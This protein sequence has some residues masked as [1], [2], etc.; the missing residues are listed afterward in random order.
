[1]PNKSFV[2]YFFRNNR[3]IAWFVGLLSISVLSCLVLWYFAQSISGEQSEQ[4]HAA[5][6]TSLSEQNYYAPKQS[7]ASC[8]DKEYRLWYDSNH[9]RAM[10]EPIT[11]GFRG[12]FNDTQYIHVGFDDLAELSDD[13]LKA[14]LNEVDLTIIAQGLTDAKPTVLL[15][16]NAVLSP[17]NQ[18]QLAK[19]THHYIASV[20]TET[21]TAKRASDGSAMTFGKVCPVRAGDSQLAHAEVVDT[22]QRLA[23]EGKIDL[24]FGQLYRFFMQ[25]NRPMVECE[26]SRGEREIFAVKYTF[27]NSPMQ[28]YLV[29]F[30]DG[31]VQCLPM[32]WDVERGRW[33]HLYPKERILHDDVLFWTRPAQN[34]NYMCAG[35]HTTN[36]HKNYD[37][38]SN[39]YRTR[40]SEMGVGCQSCHGPGGWHVER[41][42]IPGIT[43]TG[44]RATDMALPIFSQMTAQDEVETCAPC[45]AHRRVLREG[46]APPDSHFLDYYVPAMIDGNLFYADGQILE[47]DYEYTSFMQCRMSVEN[48]RCT[49][50]HDPHTSKL[51]HNGNNLCLQCHNAGYDSPKHHFHEDETQPGTQCIECH[52]PT[53]NYMVIRPRHDHNFKVPDPDLTIRLGIPNACN[54][55]H[56]DPVKSETPEWASRWIRHWY[57]KSDQTQPQ[58]EHFAYAISGG[59][60]GNADALPKLLDVAT[61]NDVKQVRPIVRASAIALLG[62]YPTAE[63]LTAR[64]TALSDDDPNVR[65]AAASTFESAMPD[66][67]LTHLLPLLDDEKY[68]IR[69]EAARLLSVVPPGW[70]PAD[71]K[72]SYQTTLRDY[73]ESQ[74]ASLDHPAAHLNLAVLWENLAMPEIYA[75]QGAMPI[76]DVRKRTQISLDAYRQALAI[77]PDFLPARINLAMLHNS[78]NEPQE[79]EIQLRRVTE[80]APENGEGF[81]SLALLLAEQNRLD[82]AEK[83]FAKAATLMPDNARLLY[84]HGLLLLQLGNTDESER[85]LIRAYQADQNSV[86]IMRALVSVSLAKREYEKALGRIQLLRRMEPNNPSWQALFN[87]VQLQYRQEQNRSE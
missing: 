45:H 16:I 7:C 39:T 9:H 32:T 50:C 8:H 76:T 66:E 11:D 21:A 38:A 53:H 44:N 3:H 27:G 82:E 70:F 64:V 58:R 65:L 56:N 85:Q 40:W 67:R 37:V 31:R 54:N 29:E 83:A 33:F 51:T 87:Q 15:R 81:Y 34:W 78:R 18:E 14:V 17:E 46:A 86:D 79:A 42:S 36:L 41:M 61:N 77:D 26:N 75:A 25:R 13:E 57:D 5:R 30:D 63:T 80:I 47:E 52:A 49:T 28:Q 23:I 24:S 10:G 35:C 20:T 68:A 73:V 2:A 59:R 48:V 62:R 69:C 4:P 6:T 74:N 1:M 55:C 60:N 71:K 72:A 22:M 43:P 84:N 19:L 12:D